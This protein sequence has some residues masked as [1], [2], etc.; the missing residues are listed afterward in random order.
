MLRNKEEIGNFRHHCC[1]VTVSEDKV[2]D[3]KIIGGSVVRY[4]R[5][6]KVM[7]SEN[8]EACLG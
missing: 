3:W 5:E 8:E 6:E 7:G 4:R 2:I 1:L